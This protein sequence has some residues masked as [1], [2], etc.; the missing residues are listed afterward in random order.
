MGSTSILYLPI[1]NVVTSHLYESTVVIFQ[2]CKILKK[3]TIFNLVLM[4][5]VI[6]ICKHN[7]IVIVYMDKRKGFIILYALQYIACGRKI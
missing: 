1:P 2:F 4:T 5:A 6:M 7:I 3:Y